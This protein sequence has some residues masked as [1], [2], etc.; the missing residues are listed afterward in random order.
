MNKIEELIA[1][2]PDPKRDKMPPPVGIDPA[3]A[4][5]AAE[6]KA[7]MTSLLDPRSLTETRVKYVLG[8]LFGVIL[9]KDGDYQ[10]VFGNRQVWVKHTADYRGFTPVPG[11]VNWATFVEVKGISPGNV[12]NMSRLDKTRAQPTQFDRLNAAHIAGN[13]VLLALGW[14]IALPG[15]E[16][17]MVK[18]KGRKITRWRKGDVY[19]EIDL[20]R[21]DQYVET[22]E[23]MTRRSIREKDRALFPPCRIRKIRNRWETCSGHWWHEHVRRD[24]LG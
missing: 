3:G 6:H 13:F 24:L 2:L 19:L 14:W 1:T 9:Q 4:V 10:T 7:L 11:Q 15:A 12:F 8:N 23:K 22:C 21:W 18:Q 20:L 5:R 16:P 17:V